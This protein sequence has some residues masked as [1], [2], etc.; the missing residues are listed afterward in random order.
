MSINTYACSERKPKK[1]STMSEKINLRLNPL[2]VCKY[3][4]QVCLKMMS[5]TA[6]LIKVDCYKHKY[7][8]S[9][10]F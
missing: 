2:K 4:W 9:Q 6:F 7:E 5:L 1:N 3:K 8:K 10:P